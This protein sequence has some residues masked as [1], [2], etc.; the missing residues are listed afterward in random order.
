MNKANGMFS[1]GR[2]NVRSRACL[3][4][5]PVDRREKFHSVRCLKS[6][7]QVGYSLQSPLG[8]FIPLKE[9]VSIGHSP[10]Q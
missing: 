6:L 3:R 10:W 4:S 8:R 9:R 1:V 2:R 7:N 5:N